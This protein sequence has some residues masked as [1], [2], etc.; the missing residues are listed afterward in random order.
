MT[1]G[2]GGE[3]GVAVEARAQAMGDAALDVHAIERQAGFGGIAREEHEGTAIQQD[4]M[5]DAGVE[6][7]EAFGG[8]TVG[9]MRQII[10]ACPEGLPAQ[11]K[12][13][14]VVGRP[15]RK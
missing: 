15:Y 12:N 4:G 13:E 10:E 14:L 11:S 6:G 9:A 8:P 1:V 3:R 7:S 5:G 2:A